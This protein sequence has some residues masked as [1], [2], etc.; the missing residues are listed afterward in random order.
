MKISDILDICN[1]NLVNFPF[2]SS[3]EGIATQ[4]NKIKRGDLFFALDTKEIESAVN[5]G[6]YAIIFD[7]PTQVTD[8][9]IAWIK[10]DSVQSAINKFIRYEIANNPKKFFLV[11]SFQYQ[12]IEQIVSTK[13]VSMLSDD[14]LENYHN[15]VNS[16]DNLFIS[17]DKEYLEFIA[18]KY[19]ELDIIETSEFE[20]KTS[21]TFELSFTFN[22]K[23]Y[24]KVKIASLFAN[25]LFKVIKFLTLKGIDFNLS[26]IES[27]SHFHPIYVDGYFSEKEYG[28]SDRVLIFEPD[29]ELVQDE[30][31][32]L[33]E[34]NS[35]AKTIVIVKSSAHSIKFDNIFIAKNNKNIIDILKRNDFNFALIVE[36]SRD[37]LDKYLNQEVIHQPTLFDL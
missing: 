5:K 11:N 2:I 24:D 3:I 35:W 16:S 4:P 33:I 31:D 21:S 29:E 23:L 9:E 28:K 1:G 15:I 26:D 32:Y 6:A 34:Q 13:Q 27:F 10:V 18:S 17:N 14:Y 30:I 22:R 25:D 7:K 20:L 37:D 12:L 8:Y 19:D 36:K